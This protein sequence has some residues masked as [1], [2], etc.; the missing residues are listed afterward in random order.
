MP[1]NQ[2][3]CCKFNHQISTRPNAVKILALSRILK[4]VFREMFRIGLD[5]Y[6]YQVT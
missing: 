5:N 2:T 3:Y 1:K 6:L 4:G